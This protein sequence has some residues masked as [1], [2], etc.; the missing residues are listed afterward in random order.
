M[1]E[2]VLGPALA[3]EPAFG[4]VTVTTLKLLVPLCL[5]I[6]VSSCHHHPTLTI[7]QVETLTTTCIITTLSVFAITWLSM[8]PLA[9]RFFH[10]SPTHSYAS[11][12]VCLIGA[13]IPFRFGLLPSTLLM[14]LAKRERT[15]HFDISRI[16]HNWRSDIIDISGLIHSCTSDNIIHPHPL[17]TE[18]PSM[19]A[20]V[21][22]HL[23]P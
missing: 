6:P 2:R 4:S 20:S 7:T 15:L 19:V 12:S 14:F 1:E 21:L 3:V 16:L 23:L 13:C 17:I 11:V 9:P 22:I 18:P 8:I 5:C 10:G